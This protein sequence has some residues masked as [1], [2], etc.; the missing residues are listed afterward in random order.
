MPSARKIAERH[1]LTEAV[2]LLE[3]AGYTRIDDATGKSDQSKWLWLNVDEGG[4]ERLFRVRFQDQR[5]MAKGTCEF[6]FGATLVTAEGRA[7]R[8]RATIVSGGL[9]VPN[10]NVG[11]LLGREVP[12]EVRDHWWKVENGCLAEGDTSIS[13]ATS[14]AI[15]WL[16][17]FRTADHVYKWLIESGKIQHAVPLGLE[18]G[19]P[20]AGDLLREQLA[21]SSSSDPGDTRWLRYPAAKYGV[22]ISDLKIDGYV[23][24]VF[25]PGVRDAHPDGFGFDFAPDEPIPPAV[26]DDFVNRL[27]SYRLPHFEQKYGRTDEDK[28]IRFRMTGNGSEILVSERE[29]T[30]ASSARSGTVFDLLVTAWDLCRTESLTFFDPQTGNWDDF[31]LSASEV[32]G[33]K[34]VLFSPGDS[35]TTTNQHLDHVAYDQLPQDTREQLVEQ[36]LADGYKHLPCVGNTGWFW[37]Q[38]HSVEVRPDR[39]V[40][41]AHPSQYPNI[42]LDESRTFQAACEIAA[43]ATLAAW[44]LQTDERFNAEL[45]RDATTDSPNSQYP[46]A[47]RRMRLAELSGFD[48]LASDTKHWYDVVLVA[49][50]SRDAFRSGVPFAEIKHEVVDESTR[51]KVIELLGRRNYRRVEGEGSLGRFEHDPGVAITVSQDRI[52]FVASNNPALAADDGPVFEVLQTSSEITSIVELAKFD[53]QPP[54]VWD[55]GLVPEN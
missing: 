20:D 12:E 2:P 21:N 44:D 35:N 28:V 46:E 13:V 40:L 43:F 55:D 8:G 33:H 32:E 23:L 41:T 15:A 31:S 14:A 18:M 42:R 17:P 16:Q 30:F 9:G 37:K 6:T 49:P 3:A 47:I 7:A 24:R 27:E 11:R 4:V 53:P 34:L 38:D 36:L 1:I 25:S 54:G 52:W 26:R 51:T 22:D 19:R 10:V 29:I 45:L 50:S 5:K 39:V 48:V